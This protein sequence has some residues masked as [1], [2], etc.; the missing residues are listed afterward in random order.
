M[1]VVNN[2]VI[3]TII[4]WESYGLSCPS[5]VNVLYKLYKTKWIKE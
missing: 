3:S 4:K 1:I 5:N 2:T